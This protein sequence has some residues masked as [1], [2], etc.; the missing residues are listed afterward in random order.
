M[1]GT[2]SPCH[3]SNM[4]IA[5]PVDL[6]WLVKLGFASVLDCFGVANL[7]T[8]DRMRKAGGFL[9]DVHIF[10]SEQD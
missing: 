5:I 9:R 10:L 1:L 6:N 2:L 7:L 4:V 8:E 3:F